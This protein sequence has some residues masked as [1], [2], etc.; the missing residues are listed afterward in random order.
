MRCSGLIACG[1]TSGTTSGTVGSS[2]N[3]EELSMTT[4]PLSAIALASSALASS[5]D[6]KNATSGLSALSRSR[7]ATATGCVAPRNCTPSARSR[8]A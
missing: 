2:R 1:L 6:A 7:V 5:L 3:V 8:E 4:P